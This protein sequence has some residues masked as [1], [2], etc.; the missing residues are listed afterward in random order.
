MPRAKIPEL[1]N[2]G[3]LIT[4]KDGDKDRCLGYLLHAKGHGVYEPEFGRVDI[5]PEQAKLHNE[6]LDQALVDGLDNCEVGQ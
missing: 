4:Y 3:S 5:S 2:L 6:L 1:Q